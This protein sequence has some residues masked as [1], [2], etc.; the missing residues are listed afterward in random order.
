M[1]EFE[2]CSCNELQVIPNQSNPQESIIVRGAPGSDLV[3]ESF[4]EDGK[5]V[6]EGSIIPYSP[7]SIVTT[8]N[9]VREVG[10]V[11]NFTWNGNIVQ[12]RNPIIRREI[13]P[14]G[15]NLNAPFSVSVTGN[16]R[17]SRGSNLAYH[18]E[19][20]DNINN[21]VQKDLSI[22][23]YNKVYQFFSYKDAV[24]QAI[25]ESDIIGG[26]GTI[27]DNI[28]SVY[29]GAKNYNVPVNALLNYIYWAYEVGTS[30]INQI[31]LNG[32]NFPITFLPGTYPVQVRNFAVTLG[33]PGDYITVNYALV[34]SAS[35]F[36]N[37]NISLVMS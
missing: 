5:K 2:S 10:T 27:A 13:T 1:E 22:I 17:S 33:Q 37:G 31:L 3:F 35:N 8:A 34:K 21:V 16:T 11:N 29:G 24:N 23:Y 18:I 19:V 30:P 25:T 4:F 26:T 36:G 7:P 9:P 15:A 32:L 28:K 14:S 12:G 6:F 20:E